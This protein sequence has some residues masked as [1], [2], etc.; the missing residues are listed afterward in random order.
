MWSNRNVWIV[1]TG[2]FVAGIGLWTAI[3]ANL[4]F[5]QRLVP[6]DFLKS[7]LLFA[8]LLSSVLVGPY[9]GRLIDR[10]GKKSILLGAGV[11]R[12]LSVCAM[13]AAL[14]FDSVGWMLVSLVVLQ[15]SGAF[16][17]PTLQAVL[18]AI[19][20]GDKLLALN[21][22]FMNVTTVARIA[23]TGLAGILLTF[24]SLRGLY[25]SSMAAYVALLAAT[26]LLRLDGTGPSSAKRGAEAPDASAQIASATVSG[27]KADGSAGDDSFR[28]LLRRLREWPSIVPLLVLTVVPTLLI[29]GFNLL[30][31][32]I[33][34]LQGAP[35]M[36]GWFY[37]AEG[38]SFILGAFAAKRL[39]KGKPGRLLLPMA[40]IMTASLFTLH[41]AAI[42]GIPFV[43]FALFGF[44]A[45]VFFPIAATLF[46]T[47][48]PAEYHGR[49]FSFR[50]MFDRVLF[51]IVLLM[52]GF[53][54]DT[55]GLPRMGLLFGCLSLAILTT[56][57]LAGSF[58][59]D[60]LMATKPDV[61]TKQTGE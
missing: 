39:T 32:E 20:A 29:G 8:G 31:I 47:K 13:F 36:K 17:F 6:S 30:V 45:G 38:V 46:Q 56:V 5:M 19:V 33:S 55:I 35:E 24:L 3:V 52:T 18:P 23:G 59:R 58:G 2:E 50:N 4:E 42:P 51:Q 15:V 53:F 22:V 37:T 14:A 41:W 34:E 60:R 12:I 26:A 21:G 44:A 27:R 10:S 25:L 9:A 49:F 7:L 57:F 40:A 11:G 48:V 43:T 54:L 16:Y 1:L 28:S 61:L